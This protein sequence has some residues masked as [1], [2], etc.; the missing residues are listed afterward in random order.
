MPGSLR[1][2]RPNEAVSPAVLV[3]PTADGPAG[4][5]SF[6]APA[7]AAGMVRLA[8]TL[9]AFLLVLKPP[10]LRRGWFGWLLL[11][12]AQESVSGEF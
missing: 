5:V 9:A 3:G 8:A 2:S 11:R 7:L 4:L 10:P 12:G 1:V 6:E